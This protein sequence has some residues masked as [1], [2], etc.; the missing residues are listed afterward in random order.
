MP[1]EQL[2]NPTNKEIIRDCPLCFRNNENEAVS[3]YSRDSWLIKTCRKCSLNYLENVIPYT[4]LIDNYA[5]TKTSEIENQFRIKR[6]P[7]LKKISNSYSWFKQNIIRRDK[8]AALIHKLFSSGNLIDIGC[9][10]GAILKKLPINVI[11]FGI[12]IELETAK[13]CNE[14]AE[15]LG[16]SV[17]H[18]NAI[19]GLNEIEAD[20]FDGVIMQSYLEHEINPQDVLKGA[21]RVLKKG[22]LAIIKVP[23]FNCWNRH[24]RQN[25]WCGFRFPDHVNYFTPQ[26]LKKIVLDSGFSIYRFN[27]VDRSPLSDNM[28]MIV[29]KL[30]NN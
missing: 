1:T 6:S 20:Y 5:W 29:E 4:E 30:E 26:T 3:I 10:S 16:G 23:N 17:W 8:G 19:S 21:L 18:N 15:T 13:L 11:P 25:N 12:E 27:L 2:L 24:L 22:G 9:G 14:Y 7:I 28:W